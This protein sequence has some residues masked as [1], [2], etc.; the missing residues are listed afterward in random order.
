MSKPE[1]IKCPD[2]NGPMV[3]RDGKFGKFWGCM[4][5]P[6]CK[7]TRDSMGLSKRDREK[8]LN[9]EE[10]FESGPFDGFNRK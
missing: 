7:G 3:P 10:D 9:K 8:E 1:N 2:C 4:S 6:L 5:F